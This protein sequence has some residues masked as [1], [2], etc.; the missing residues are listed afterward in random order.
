M[1]LL[2]YPQRL[3]MLLYT[4]KSDAWRG[5]QPLLSNAWEGGLITNILQEAWPEDHI[6]KAMVLSPGEAILFFGR[7]SKNEGLLYHR[8]RDIKFGLGD[9]F[10]WVGGQC[11]LKLGGKLCR[12]VAMPSLRL[13]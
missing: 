12:K 3:K 2:T 11:R 6:T 9:P 13:W 8:A 4:G 1:R 7:H 10:N 5:D